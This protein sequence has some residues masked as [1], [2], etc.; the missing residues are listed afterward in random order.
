MDQH[1]PQLSLNTNTLKIGIRRYCRILSI[2]LQKNTV[3]RSQKVERVFY[4][5]YRCTE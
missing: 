4:P 2:S 5:D 1:L 3:S